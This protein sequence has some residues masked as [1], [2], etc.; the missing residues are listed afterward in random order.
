MSKKVLITRT[1]KQSQPF[2]DALEKAGFT[3]VFFPT[4]SIDVVDDLR[5]LE[6]ALRQIDSYDWVLF[7]SPN[8]VDVFF[9]QFPDIHFSETKVAAV[10]T[11]TAEELQERGI[12]VNLV[13]DEFDGEGLLVSL[14]DVKGKR[15]LLPRAKVARK[16]LPDEIRKAGGILDEFAIYETVAAKPTAEEIE[17]LREGVDAVTFTSPSTVRNFIKLAKEFDIDPFNLPLF[18][19][20]GPVTEKAAREAGFSSVVMAETYTTDGLIEILKNT[21]PER[22]AN[23]ESL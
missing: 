11:K 8:A 13:P 22:K 5:D 20:I 10:G 15:F 16:I 19:C 14:G 2:A 23:E 4:I 12:E 18:A 6:E 17:A 9:T 7:T 3:P 1:R 21:V